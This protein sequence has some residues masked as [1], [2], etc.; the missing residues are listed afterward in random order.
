MNIVSQKVSKVHW[1][2]YNIGVNENRIFY[3]NAIM[4]INR[5]SGNAYI[6][7]FIL[8]PPNESI[9]LECDQNEVDFTPYKFTFVPAATISMQVMAK[10]NE[11]SHMF[12]EAKLALGRLPAP[13]RRKQIK[14]RMK[15]LE[16]Y[17]NRKGLDF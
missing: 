6:N 13:D 9:S 16:G 14:E 11:G 5:G 2:A 17:Y 15:Y 7:D 3:C 4:F 10:E 12:V 8:V 1:R